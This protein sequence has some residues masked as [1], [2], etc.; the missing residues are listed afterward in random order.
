VA[1][2]E[3]AVALDPKV[4]G[5]ELGPVFALSQLGGDAGFEGLV[6]A[7]EIVSPKRTW[8]VAKY[9]AETDRADALSPLRHVLSRINVRHQCNTFT[10][11]AYAIRGLEEEIER[12][13]SGTAD[14][15]GQVTRAAKR[16]N[17]TAADAA[18]ARFS[19]AVEK[20]FQ[21][22]GPHI[23]VYAYDLDTGQALERS[24]APEG[25]TPVDAWMR[26]T[27]ADLR[28]E[29]DDEQVTLVAVDLDLAPLEPKDW[30]AVTPA[31]LA[32]AVGGET[33]DGPSV[34]RHTI[35]RALNVPYAFR[36][37]EGGIGMFRPTRWIDHAPGMGVELTVLERPA[38]EEDTAPVEVAMVASPRDASL[39]DPAS[40]YEPTVIEARD[41]RVR[42]EQDGNVLVAEQVVVDGDGRVTAEGNASGGAEEG[43]GKAVE[44]VQCRLRPVKTTWKAGEAPK[45]L[46][47]V[48]NRGE[49]VFLVYRAQEMCELQVDGRWYRWAGDISVK[50]SPF[51]PGREYTGIPIT[52]AGSWARSGTAKSPPL[53]LEPGRHTVRVAVIARPQGEAIARL[54]DGRAIMD[55]PVRAVSNPV[56][57]V[58]QG[59][60]ASAG[61]RETSAAA[62]VADA[63]AA[64]EPA[65]ASA[66]PGR[67]PPD[68]PRPVT[69]ECRH[70]KRTL[71]LAPGQWVPHGCSLSVPYRGGSHVTFERSDASH[72]TVRIDGGP[73]Q[74]A[75][76]NAN[77]DK[78]LDVAKRDLARGTRGFLVLCTPDR[79][80]ALPPLP[81]G[82][83]L[84]LTVSGGLEDF[85]PLMRHTG[86]SALTIFSRELT[87][88]GPLA[89]FRDLTSVRLIGCRAVTD[90]A[91][92]ARLPRLTWLRIVACPAIED[93]SPLAEAPALRGLHVRT[94]EAV[95]DLD[96]LAG[97]R[98]LQVLH[99]AG[100]E[101]VT[102]LAPLGGLAD[103][104]V[105]HL[106][107]TQARD[108]A[109]LASLARLEELSL[110]ASKEVADLGPLAGLER[111]RH[112]DL[113]GCD[114]V[115][116][117]TP[118]RG[119]IRRG[120]EVE[121]DGNLRN[122]LARLRDDKGEANAPRNREP[123]GTGGV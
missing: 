103:L 3:Q 39:A 123:P 49:R 90:L 119:V 33:A 14:L 17:A 55:E 81:A 69:V 41:G 28:I 65:V 12:P 107:S 99:L 50:S 51:S 26:A 38:P 78:G 4:A 44:G 48:R 118:L 34:R 16:R 87:D 40:Q 75:W 54:D 11:L 102:D 18:D 53:A 22:M 68:G 101:S 64:A 122:E 59:P 5:G 72:M 42:I 111:L 37:R 30:N 117:L 76:I 104:R 9:L 36:T 8:L 61:P 93:F 56:A 71:R 45:L 19:P 110:F 108:L 109:P 21:D 115:T 58:V 25:Q 106:T 52:L 70:G 47:D 121:V 29:A 62:P 35:R 66:A 79:L 89:E 80:D 24:V 20:S 120:G 46:A 10:H 15:Y 27:G 23:W 60:E 86:V 6:R 114:A 97:L 63:P 32:E 91:P 100:A 94:G 2:L 74:T 43:W 77:T 31:R 98:R 67:A 112:V 113:R 105:L 96:F 83:D 7:L 73:S 1:A 95:S 85:E 82:R 116:E 13:V 88:L 84:A 57:V 92:V